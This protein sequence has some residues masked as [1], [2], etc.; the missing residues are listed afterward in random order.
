[1]KFK[2]SKPDARILLILIIL[3]IWLSFSLS[4]NRFM[5]VLFLAVDIALLIGTNCDGKGFIKNTVVYFFLQGLLVGLSKIQF[6]FLD[7]VLLPF[8][9]IMIRVY[10]VMLLLELF[11]KRIPVNE[12]MYSLERMHMPKS[13]LIPIMVIYRYVPTILKEIKMIRAGIKMRGLGCRMKHP[14]S[15][16]NAA[17]YYMTALISRSEKL[18]DELSAAAICKGLSVKRDRSCI[19]K[20]KIQVPDMIVLCIGIVFMAGMF[21]LNQRLR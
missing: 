1:M 12:L 13:V 17:N 21:Y 8:I 4:Q 15:I 18:S 5:I 14:A 16:I 9:M 2:S 7:V 3:G 11:V 6:P 20:V 19:T 10:P